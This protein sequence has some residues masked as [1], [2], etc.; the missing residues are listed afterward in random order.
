M[1]NKH[2]IWSLI[3]ALRAHIM[4]VVT[5][6]FVWNFMRNEKKI[7][8]R[9]KKMC[10]CTL[11]ERLCCIVLLNTEKR[12]RFFFAASEYVLLLIYLSFSSRRLL[13]SRFLICLCSD[14]GDPHFFTSFHFFGAR[15]CI[16]RSYFL[17]YFFF[18]FSTIIRSIFVWVVY[19]DNLSISLWLCIRCRF[20]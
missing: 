19:N 8:R 2:T 1:H 17:R 9:T 14:C 10:V 6:N 4:H 20:P 3:F 7:P 13:C 12:K 11:C 5:L 18:L 15:T 16:F